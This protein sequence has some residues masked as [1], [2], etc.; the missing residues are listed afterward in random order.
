LKSLLAIG[1]W[2][3]EVHNPISLKGGKIN[4]DDTRKD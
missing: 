3:D 4:G 2:G 1:R